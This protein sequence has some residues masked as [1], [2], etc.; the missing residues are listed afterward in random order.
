MSAVC[1][2]TKNGKGCAMATWQWVTIC[3]P[4]VVLMFAV[5]VRSTPFM[6]K[7]VCESLTAHNSP[8]GT[9][10]RY[11]SQRCIGVWQQCMAL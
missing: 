11:E 10:Y 9:N 1:A 7:L 2:K 6:V 5:T 4:V 8:S 3:T